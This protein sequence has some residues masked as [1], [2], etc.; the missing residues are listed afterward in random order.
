MMSVSWLRRGVNESRRL[1][2]L[3]LRLS[4]NLS[5]STLL[6]SNSLEHLRLTLPNSK[7]PSRSSPLPSSTHRAT[8]GNAPNQNPR[9]QQRR[10]EIGHPLPP[11]ALLL[12]LHRDPLVTRDPQLVLSLLK[13][14]L[15][16]VGR[17]DLEP[18]GDG[19]GGGRGSGWDE[20][21]RGRGVELGVGDGAGGGGGG[22]LTW[23]DE[24]DLGSFFVDDGDF[25]DEAFGEEGVSAEKGRK[26]GELARS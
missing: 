22:S 26:E 6:S 20:G 21:R 25:G 18:V 5:S 15:E 16:R 23:G 13:L 1:D 10:S 8:L 19:R 2:Q 4:P 11:T 14:S 7:D 17:T 12:V 24:G 9:D 3:K